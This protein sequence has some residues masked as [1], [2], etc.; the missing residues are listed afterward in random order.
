MDT[1]EI[2]LEHIRESVGLTKDNTEFDTELLN[3]INLSVVKINQNGVKLNI[4]KIDSDTTWDELLDPSA[5]GYDS[6]G[7][8]PTFM[9]LNVKLLFDPPPPSSVDFHVRTM[10]ETL[11][12]L[13][14]AYEEEAKE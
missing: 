10:D 6:T 7:A 13:K 4:D 8:L 1:S 2:I 3:Y 9:A 11:W 5:E 14:L 12:R